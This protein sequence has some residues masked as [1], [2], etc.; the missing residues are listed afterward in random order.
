LE[1]PPFAWL[2]HLALFLRRRWRGIAISLGVCV[3]AAL[4][5]S[6]TATPRYTA[7]LELLIDISRTDQ[8]RQQT[9]PHDALTLNSML[10]SQ[11]QV[12][13]SAGLARRTALRL[14]LGDKTRFVTTRP[15]V[16]EIARAKLMSS[17]QGAAAPAR[18]DAVDVAAQTLLKMTRVRRIGQTY[19]I[20]IAVTSA[21]PDEAALL[22]NGIAQTYLNEELRAKE[23]GIQQATGWLEVRIKE[24]NNEALTADRAVQ[25]FK[26]EHNIVDTEKGLMGSQQLTELTSQLVTARANSA[27]ML[28][29]LHRIQ[30]IISDGVDGG[31]VTDSL[32]NKVIVTLRQQYVDDDRRLAELSAKYGKDH[33]TIRDLRNEMVEVKK[34][35]QGELARIADTYKS[36]YEVARANEASVQERLDQMVAAA[37]QTNNDLVVLRSLQSS[38][39]TFRTLYQ[40]FLQRYT[41]AVQDQ[42]FPVP[43]ARVITAAIAPDRKSEPKTTIILAF[44]VVLGG[45]IGFTTAVARETL[46]RGIRDA[47]QLRGATGLDCLGFVPRLNRLEIHRAVRASRANAQV[48]TMAPTAWRHE[49]LRHVVTAP[50]S[51]FSN[52]IRAIR[53]HIVYRP[54]G[55]REIKVIGCLPTAPGAGASTIAANLALALART[56]GKTILVDWDFAN[57]SLSRALADGRS[58][59]CL[60][61]LA[62]R[63]DLVGCVRRDRQTEV[64]FLT[65]GY[66]DSGSLPRALAVSEQMCDLL[67]RLRGAY[68]YVVV[69]LPPLTS[70]AE[71]HYAARLADTIIIVAEWGR[72]PY[73]SLT[74]QL[75][76]LGLDTTKLMGVVLNKA[77]PRQAANDAV[78]AR[79]RGAA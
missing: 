10:E 50:R 34:S 79:D 36:D 21:S 60:D 53:M 5:Y 55:A 57:A 46:D 62:G 73:A 48:N 42:S 49:I 63:L 40:N 65:A 64:D 22:A 20:G 15:S 37:A 25:D 24:L 51:R 78:S 52:A 32:D 17:V 66:A 47:R 7:E 70:P 76:L 61:V 26:A 1:P 77:D 71:T 12:L 33:M 44:A 14:G 41:Q 56:G 29:R 67:A 38:A 69:D 19:I 68:G 58:T 72:P 16:I 59:G 8:L 23:D 28:A 3:A 35:I 54:P 13:Q 11:V 27:T 45:G 9:T 6:L 18:A 39:D 2:P 75:D 43:E 30:A 74:E 31:G 4:L